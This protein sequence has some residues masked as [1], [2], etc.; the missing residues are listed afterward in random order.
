MNLTSPYWSIPM[1][2]TNAG[3]PLQDFIGFA[4]NLGFFIERP[5]PLPV[6]A[7]WYDG[8]TGLDAVPNRNELVMKSQPEY[9][10][11]DN[12]IPSIGGYALINPYLEIY[13]YRRA[14]YTIKL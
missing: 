7:G 12:K 3:K 1:T 6:T 9:F 2:D 4:N 14:D 8:P 10:T 13:K 11:Q 5:V